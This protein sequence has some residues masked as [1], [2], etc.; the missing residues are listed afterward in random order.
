MSSRAF[1]GGAIAGMAG[2]AAAAYIDHR[3]T[4]SKFSPELK[5]P[6]ILGKEQ[7]IRELSNYFFKA[8]TLLCKCNEIVIKNSSLIVTPVPLPGDNIFQRAANLA[9][10]RLTQVC[11]KGSVGQLLDCK[12]D[13]AQLYERYLGIFNRANGLLAEYG[14]T[15]VPVD[16]KLFSSS[17]LNVDDSLEN[18]DWDTEFGKLA[19]QIRDAIDQSCEKAQKLIET[20]EQGKPAYALSPANS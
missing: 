13:A 8:Q 16:K 4:E 10:G 15:P 12:K 9:G 6:E 18:E 7:V 1:I 14:Q 11:R 19:D 20:L 17:N 2:L 3:I 5:T